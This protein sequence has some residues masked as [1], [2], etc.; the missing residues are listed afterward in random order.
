MQYSYNELRRRADACQ[1]LV[2]AR[3]RKLYS[4]SGLPPRGFP[5]SARTAAAAR[6]N[7]TPWADVDYTKVLKIVDLQ[8]NTLYRAHGLLMRLVFKGKTDLVVRFECITHS[9]R[10]LPSFTTAPPTR[11]PIRPTNTTDNARERYRRAV[12]SKG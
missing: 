2:Y 8:D 6:R 4:E 5:D 1:A 7:N 9:R 3:M 10:A 12:A 11:E